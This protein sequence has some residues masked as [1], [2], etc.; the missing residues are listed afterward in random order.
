MTRADGLDF[1]SV[2]NHTDEG[3]ALDGYSSAAEYVRK[4]KA[5]GH[6]G[7]GITDHGG[8]NGL[9]SL[10]AES[11]KAGIVPVPGCELYMA[12]E[13][14]DGAKCRQRVFYG[15]EEQR[16][17]GDDV[18]SNG[19]YTHLTVW[20]H[21]MMGLRNLYRLSLIAHENVYVKPRVDLDILSAHSDGLIVATGCP[22]SELST[23]L[24]LGQS[25]EA[26]QYI[27]RMVD[28][29]G[30][31][32][33][34]EVMAHDMELEKRLIAQQMPF[35]QEARARHGAASLPLL[36]TNDAHYVEQADAGR[37]EEMLCVSSSSSSHPVT[38]FDKP[39]SEGGPRFAF[40]GS[41]YYLRTAR[42]MY[43]ALRRG[44]FTDSQARAGL[45]GS[46]DIMERCEGITVDY[47]Q[48]LRPSVDVGRRSAVEVLWEKAQAGV[49]IRFP[50]AS[51]KELRAVHERMEE[52]MR[53]IED[54]GF[55]QYFLVIEKLV[56]YANREHSIRDAD[57]SI[58]V[59]AV[60]MGRGS[61][62]SSLILYLTGVTNVDPLKYNLSFE[63]FLS[64]GRGNEVAIP[65][66]GGRELRIPS[67]A[68][69]PLSEGSWKRCMDI[70][71]GDDI[72]DSF[73]E[74][75]FAAS[76]S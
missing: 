60:G 68:P 4:A 37:H 48:H 58:L 49:P 39:Y 7:I 47:D 8:M 10:I 43:D 15:T 34:F 64:P 54:G 44:G 75:F 19:A 1:V 18:S 16:R 21:N 6:R 63:R 22:S 70:E 67:G 76:G 42:E 59:Y 40:N 65:V 28:V 3:S 62:P 11:K 52:E 14:P 51:E 32:L 29:F 73:V 5:L 20:A 36:A 33:F 26:M 45:A 74:E 35:L 27:D 56:S 30:D 13:N 9:H 72:L 2:H 55:E 50:G 69:V 41:G 31:R 53:T 25:Q 24:R 12:P 61:A 23:R 38:M 17:R 66:E 71:S 57:G 46:L